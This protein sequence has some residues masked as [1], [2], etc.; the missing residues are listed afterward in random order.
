MNT[1]DTIAEL[2]RQYIAAEMVERVKGAFTDE[3]ANVKPD[4]EGLK[5]ARDRMR[6]MADWIDEV[7]AGRDHLEHGPEIMQRLAELSDRTFGGSDEPD[8]G[9]TGRE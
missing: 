6:W 2:R 1:V 8:A 4:V 5:H 3:L 9:S 7:L